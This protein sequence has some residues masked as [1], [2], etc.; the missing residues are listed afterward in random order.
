MLSINYIFEKKDEDENKDPKFFRRF[1]RGR[2]D[3][4]GKGVGQP[5]GLRRNRNTE[6]CE[7]VSGSGEGRGQGQNR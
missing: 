6:P 4:S 5:G 1:F 3:G 2:K 7:D